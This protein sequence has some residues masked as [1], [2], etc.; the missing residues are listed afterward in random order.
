MSANCNM[1][2]IPVVPVPPESPV[3]PVRPANLIDV[4]PFNG[5]PLIQ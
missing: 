1:N 3:P 2:S 4:N 5:H